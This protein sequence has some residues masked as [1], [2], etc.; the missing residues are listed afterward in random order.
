MYFIINCDNGRTLGF[1][2]DEDVK[3]VDVV[4]IE[5]GMT[6]VVKVT[7]GQGAKS[8]A[9]F[10]LDAEFMDNFITNTL[11]EDCCIEKLT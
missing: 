6:L 2:G 5:V 1:K 7:R 10:N 8:V 11:L 9:P 4:S 3:Y